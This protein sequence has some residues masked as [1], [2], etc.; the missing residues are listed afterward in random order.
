MKTVYKIFRDLSIAFV[1]II[2]S[3]CNDFLETTPYDFV[4]PE[5]FYSNESECTMALAGVYWT[6]VN[7]EIYGN[8]YSCMISNVDDLSYYQRAASATVSH[9][10]GN[11]HTP[12]NS[13]VYDTW[14]ALYKG[15]NNANMLLENVDGADMD[16]DVKKRIKGEAKFLRAYYHFLLVQGWY[17]VPLR[18]ESFKDVNNSPLAATPHVEALDWIIQEMEECVDMVDDSSYDLSPSHVK[19]TTVMGILARVYLWKAGYP[20][21]GGTACYAKAAEWAK[22]VKDSNKHHLNPDIYAIWKAMASDNYDT[23]FNESIWEAE[24]IGTRDDGNYTMSRIGNVI[25][26]IQSCSTN[27]CSGYSYGFYAGSLILWDLFDSND[28]RRDLSMAPYQIN[29]KD[30]KVD[31]KPAAIVQRCCGKFRREWETAVNKNKNWTPENYPILRYADVLLMLA[32][33]ENEANQH[34]TDLAYECINEIRERAGITPLHDLSYS[35]FQQKVRDERGR[36]LCF[37]SLRKYDLV[38]WGIYVKTIHDDLGAATDDPRWTATSVPAKCKGAKAFAERTQ[39][40][41][42]FLPIPTKELDVNDA[43]SQNDYWISSGETEE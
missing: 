27:P 1:L 31:W 10:Y 5:T 20:A 39:K 35:D 2:T 43:L 9:V 41:H 26:N 24:F 37:E 34:P 28:S 4:A 6:L 14:A 25:G 30:V 13:T 38:R 18:K 23:E 22:K 19:K 3:S 7:Q 33:A 16:D 32:E 8:Y 17:Q 12:G 40:K 36:E 15:I 29:A 42:Q 21:N 11:D